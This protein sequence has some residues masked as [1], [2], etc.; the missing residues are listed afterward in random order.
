MDMSGQMIYHNSDPDKSKYGDHL[1]LDN[2]VAL[3]LMIHGLGLTE[4]AQIRS[5]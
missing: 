2:E 1:C 3:R 4:I 5:I